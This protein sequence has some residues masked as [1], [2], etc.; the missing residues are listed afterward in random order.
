MLLAPA[1]KDGL[2]VLRFVPEIMGPVLL[3][4]RQAESEYSMIE[5]LCQAPGRSREQVLP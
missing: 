3:S 4:V 5:C 2:I 1:L